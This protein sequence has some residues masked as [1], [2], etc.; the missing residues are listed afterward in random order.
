MNAVEKREKEAAYRGSRV[1]SVCAVLSSV[2]RIG[3]IEKLV[4]T[5]SRG[6]GEPHAYL[7]EEHS[8][9]TQEP[10]K[11]PTG[12]RP[13]RLKEEHGPGHWKQNGR[14]V[15]EEGMSAKS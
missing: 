8:L 11:C 13:G 6:G 9:Q 12:E 4:F 15:R 10:E 2:A 3:L 14:R 7:K 1:P 5:Q